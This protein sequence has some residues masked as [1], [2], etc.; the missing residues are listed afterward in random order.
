MQPPTTTHN[1]PQ[2]PATTQKNTRNHPQPSTTNQ[3]LRT[4]AK[5]CHKQLCYWTL[6]VN[7]ETDV[8]F[9]SDMKQWCIYM[10]VCVCLCVYIL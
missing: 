8:D 6:H 9:D 10:C 4:K 5:T 3:K 1:Y 7:T 2:P